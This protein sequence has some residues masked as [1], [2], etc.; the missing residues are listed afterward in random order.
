MRRDLWLVCTFVCFY[1]WIITGCLEI[2]I[3][4]KLLYFGAST[5][6]MSNIVN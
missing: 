1:K 6:L 4:A 5:H 2:L 3:Q